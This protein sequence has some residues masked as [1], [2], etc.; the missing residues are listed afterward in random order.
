M[1]KTV[2]NYILFE[3]HMAI[4]WDPQN[5]SDYNQMLLDNGYYPVTI[6]REVA[7]QDAL[8]WITARVAAKHFTWTDSKTFWFD[9]Q[10]LAIQFALRFA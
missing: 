1:R 8:A 5:S 9:N 3:M 4:D 2:N 10:E 7:W 6:N